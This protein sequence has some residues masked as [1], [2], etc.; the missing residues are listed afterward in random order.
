LNTGLRRD[1]QELKECGGI[2]KGRELGGRAF[3][4]W[5][6]EIEFKGEMIKVENAI[7]IGEFTRF[8]GG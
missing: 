1:G 6:G 2:Q 5:E 7:G 3:I 4:S 8:E